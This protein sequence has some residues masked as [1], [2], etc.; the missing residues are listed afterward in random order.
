MG[1]AEKC[2]GKNQKRLGQIPA[3]LAVSLNFPEPPFPHLQSGDYKHFYLEG[4][5]LQLYKNARP[6]YFQC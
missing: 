5:F 6:S 4:L 1:E 2:V 3:L